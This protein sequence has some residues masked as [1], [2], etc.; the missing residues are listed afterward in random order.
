MEVGPTAYE[1]KVA[2]FGRWSDGYGFRDD[3]MNDIT[4][5]VIAW[6]PLPE[7]YKEREENEQIY[8]NY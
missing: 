5:G 3:D 2:D 8:F 1:T 6:Q 4:C 7:P